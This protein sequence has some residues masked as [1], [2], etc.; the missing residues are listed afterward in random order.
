MSGWCGAMP[1]KADHERQL[2]RGETDEVIV[3]LLYHEA[4]LWWVMLI[5]YD[6]PS[7]D[8]AFPRV[9]SQSRL[10]GS[11]QPCMLMLLLHPSAPLWAAMP[12]QNLE[13]VITGAGPGPYTSG[14]PSW[15]IWRT[16]LGQ[17]RGNRVGLFSSGPGVGILVQVV[18][19]V[20]WC[21]AGHLDGHW[22]KRWTRQ[23]LFVIVAGSIASVLDISPKERNHKWEEKDT[24]RDRHQ[25]KLQKR[26]SIC[27]GRLKVKKEHRV[28]I[29][30]LERRP[31][32]SAALLVGDDPD[33]S[34]STAPNRTNQSPSTVGP[35]PTSPTVMPSPHLYRH[36]P[37]SSRNHCA[38]LQTA[39]S[40]RFGD[41]KEHALSLFTRVTSDPDNPTVFDSNATVWGHTK[42]VPKTAKTSKL[43]INFARSQP[44][45]E[46]IISNIDTESSKPSFSRR[47]IHIHMRG[48][49]TG[50]LHPRN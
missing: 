42:S 13:G 48:P 9:A 11:V 26:C 22:V 10:L 1:K 12:K 28:D 27:S 24:S 30:E 25:V 44:S 23:E 20:P 6:L 38:N 46:V 34:R 43:G 32:W 49:L 17:R 41:G 4:K 35:A 36:Q 50:P 33:E 8:L 15:R 45:P 16:N 14:A 40:F 7:I 19:I 29:G 5:R 39:S 21:Y 3:S 18:W 47:W 2:C 37:I 31:C